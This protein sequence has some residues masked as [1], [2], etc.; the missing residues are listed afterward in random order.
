LRGAGSARRDGCDDTHAIARERRSESRV[1]NSV[2]E[3]RSSGELLVLD[4]ENG[5]SSGLDAPFASWGCD[6]DDP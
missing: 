6:A 1:A 5:A 3:R 4:S 2:A